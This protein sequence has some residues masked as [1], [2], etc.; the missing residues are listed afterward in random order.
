MKDETTSIVT[1]KEILNELNY[2]ARTYMRDA[3]TTKSAMVNLHPTKRIHWVI[4]VDEFDCDSNGCPHLVIV[5]NQIIRGT[6][7]EYQNL[8]NDS[9]VVFFC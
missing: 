7:S 2:L 6:N 3:F 9:Y 8:K 1:T 5:M 4:F